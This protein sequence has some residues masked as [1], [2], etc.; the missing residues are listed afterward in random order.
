MED[1][2]L[3]GRYELHPRL[4]AGGMGH[5]YR[6]TARNT[7]EQV[8]VKIVDREPTGGLSELAKESLGVQR[9]LAGGAYAN[10]VRIIEV[11]EDSETIAVV[12][13]LI[14]G[15]SL[16][17]YLSRAGKLSPKEGLTLFRQLLRGLSELHDRGIAHRDIKPENI[18]LDKVKGSTTVKIIDFGIA[19]M[20]PEPTLTESGVVAGT[21]AYMAPEVL[22]GTVDGGP[23]ADM[24]AAGVT[25]YEM[26]AGRRPF[27]DGNV[28]E[29]VIQHLT[30]APSPIEGLG[31]VGGGLWMLLTSL[32]AKNPED[33]PSAD[34]ALVRLDDIE[35][36]V[37]FDEPTAD[38]VPTARNWMRAPAAPAS[39]QASR[40]GMRTV[41]D[42]RTI[43]R[44]IP[45]RPV[46][47][48]S[49]RWSTTLAAGQPPRD[50]EIR[51]SDGVLHRFDFGSNEFLLVDRMDGK[52]T[53]NW[54]TEMTPG[55]F[56]ELVD[57]YLEDNNCEA[58]AT[59]G[60][61]EVIDEMGAEM[62]VALAR[63]G[64]DSFDQACG[65]FRFD[66]EDAT[67]VYQVLPSTGSQ[68]K[69]AVF[70]VSS[71]HMG[72]DRLLPLIMRTGSVQVIAHVL[73]VRADAL[74]RRLV[75]LMDAQ[76]QIERAQSPLLPTPSAVG[77][78]SV[79]DEEERGGGS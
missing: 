18:L 34:E 28:E 12:M 27:P 69:V 21:L 9:A 7:G 6:A 49:A 8:A 53:L 31:D 60:V 48:R 76:E 46:R 63:L 68:E 10:L 30:A 2:T 29:T 42:S 66:A 44:V 78:A 24:Y 73:S 59:I 74:P 51:H 32:L 50:E 70:G 64:G 65:F 57:Q 56:A 23:A 22:S 20:R 75:A 3:G 38:D 13:E 15:E 25:F 5:V 33:R 14:E 36:A 54:T 26:L 77:G 17:A 72:L 47:A 37:H 55:D 62:G 1:L 43:T 79:P 67:I 19:N 40:T 41:T 52:P 71:P 58:K 11:V 16:R 61:G 4:G 39:G 35:A 45:L